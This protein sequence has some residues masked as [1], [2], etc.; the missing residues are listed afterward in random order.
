MEEAK[1]LRVKIKGRN[2]LQQGTATPGLRESCDAAQNLLNFHHKPPQ[3]NDKKNPQHSTET[4]LK[5]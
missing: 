2:L 1:N 5:K 3:E 4:T